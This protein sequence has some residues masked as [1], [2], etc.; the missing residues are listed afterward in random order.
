[1]KF[2]DYITN[3]IDGAKRALKPA[4]LVVLLY[5]VLV[6]VTYIPTLLTIFNPFLP[7]SLSF[8]VKP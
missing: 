4:V 7:S 1:M 3:F 8:V 6:A 5:V 2:T